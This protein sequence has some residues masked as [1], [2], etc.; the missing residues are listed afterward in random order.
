MT[1][2]T[3]PPPPDAAEE[4]R[5]QRVIDALLRAEQGA[6]AKRERVRRKGRAP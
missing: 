1:T 3:K 6:Q 2:T 5:K 4:A